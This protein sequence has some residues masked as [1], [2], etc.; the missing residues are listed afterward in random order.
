MVGS[1]GFDRFGGV[2]VPANHP[3]VR[4]SLG[5][6][7]G[8]REISVPKQS[9]AVRDPADSVT[10]SPPG[11]SPQRAAEARRLVDLERREDR[12]IIYVRDTRELIEALDTHTRQ[13]SFP[14]TPVTRTV[15]FG[16]DSRG[17][18]PGLSIKART[19]ERERLPGRWDLDPKSKFELLE[20]KRTVQ[21]DPD[22]APSMRQRRSSIAKSKQQ[23]RDAMVEILTLS[24]SILGRSTHKAKQRKPSITLAD[25]L[26]VISD[27]KS[28]RKTVNEELYVH[29]LE[30]VGPFAGFAWLPV[31]GTEYERTH[32]VTRDEQYRD[33]F[34]ATL[35]RRV[36]HYTFDENGSGFVG[37]PV[38]T[39]DFSR[40]EVKLDEARLADT[41]LGGW[42]DQMVLAFRAFR[43]PSK[44]YRGMTLRSAF[45]I[46]REGLRNELPG[47]RVY[48]ELASRPVRYRD[49]EHYVNLARYIQS[50]KAFRLYRDK[51]HLL[52]KHEHSVQGRYKGL[53]VTISGSH[54][55]Y[56]RDR[57]LI[58]TRPVP[59]FQEDA[60]PVTSLPLT[61]RHDLDKSTGVAKMKRRESHYIRSRGF[62]VENRRSGRLYGVGLER[63][64]RGDTSAAYFAVVEYVGRARGRPRF[65]QAPILK[66]LTLLH[67]FLRR[68]PLLKPT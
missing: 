64:I 48:T 23:T 39:E 3:T 22:P 55:G 12:Y 43:I 40:F 53:S 32:F 33:V 30:T 35:D 13:L 16:D 29:L 59:I 31:I 15:Y 54:V 38:G 28:V 37:V 5:R 57:E 9:G 41:E 6:E 21:V 27:P 58:A 50:S 36:T 18:P 42:L 51:P 63:R 60:R 20:I 49:H 66:D 65:D 52:E 68:D 67:R 46:R 2:E 61:S 17:L 19:Y 25:L 62:L 47:L 7:R 4:V 45:Q 8:I 56:W 44:K 10:P 26:R 11:P 24:G 14:S 34:R 1:M